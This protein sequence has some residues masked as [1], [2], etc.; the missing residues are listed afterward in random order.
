[1]DTEPVSNKSVTAF[2]QKYKS[3]TV[4]ATTASRLD[5]IRVP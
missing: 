5:C 4:S 3:S 1:M 2:D